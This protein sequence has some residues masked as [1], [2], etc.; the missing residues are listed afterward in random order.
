M[1]EIIMKEYLRNRGMSDQDFMIRLKEVLGSERYDNKGMGGHYNDMYERYNNTYNINRHSDS[2]LMDLVESLSHEDK[3]R[4]MS[5]VESSVTNRNMYRNM[6]R[7]NGYIDESYAKH[8]V[9]QM[10]HISNGRKHVG[11]KYDMHKAKEIK[12]RYNGTIPSQYSLED[13]YI[14][15]NAQYHDYCELFKNWFGDNIDNKIIESAIVF[16]FK[17]VDYTDGSK[18]VNY[19][20]NK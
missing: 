19:F 12:E 5:I 1:D 17:D 11:E 13:V 14:A 3:K 10:Y 7:N 2:Q 6:S 4:L 9:S 15:I 16:W 20:M 8:I 18:I